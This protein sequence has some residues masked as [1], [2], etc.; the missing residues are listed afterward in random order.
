LSAEEKD[1]LS[2]RGKALAQ[3]VPALRSLAD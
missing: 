2:H 3:L 1:V